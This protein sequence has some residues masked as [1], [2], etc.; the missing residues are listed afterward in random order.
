MPLV[1][2]DGHANWHVD[3]V[4]SSASDSGRSSVAFGT[5][6]FGPLTQTIVDRV[7][8]LFRDGIKPIYDN[9]WFVGGV[10]VL[11]NDAGTM[12]AWE[13]GLG[14]AGTASAR[15]CCP[16]ATSH[17]VSKRTGLA[18]KAHRGRLYLPGVPEGD[19]DEAGTLSNGYVTAIQTVLDSLQT[20]V[21]GDAAI[22][23]LCLFHDD[24]TPGALP[25]D[26]V[27]SLQLKS[28]VGTMRPRQRR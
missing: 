13:Q 27:L 20:A 23:N 28:T 16:P 17:V 4:N 24:S 3:I 11:E 15:D 9:S 8:N 6:L 22:V 21:E 2:P 10:R 12:K 25:P 26:Q 7:A 18:G 14:E 19:V 1:I 5:N